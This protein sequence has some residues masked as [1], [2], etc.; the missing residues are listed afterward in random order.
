MAFFP[1][2]A[3]VVAAGYQSIGDGRGARSSTSSTTATRRTAG[4]SIRIAIEC[5]VLQRQP[6]GSKE[7]ASAM[8]PE[9]GQDFAEAPD[10]A[11]TL[12]PWLTTR[13]SL[14]RCRPHR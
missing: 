4:N 9:P 7:V 11:G 10:I 5:I 3:A 2:E 6:D 8:C 13:T 12:T 14:G 1:N